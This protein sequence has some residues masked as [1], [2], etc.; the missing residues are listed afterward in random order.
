MTDDWIASYPQYLQLLAVGFLWINLH[1]A[2]MC[3]PLVIGL[4]LGGVGEPGDA[5]GEGSVADLS[6]W[7][8]L[9]LA[10]GNLAAYQ[11]G[12]SVTYAAM[13]AAAGW[14]G[15]VL[16]RL[17]SDVTRI[18][19]LVVAVGLVGAGLMSLL[20][21]AAR[22][23][24]LSSSKPGKLMGELVNRMRATGGRRRRFGLGI[25]LG[26]LPCMIPVWVLGLAAS[27][28]SPFHGAALMVMLVWMT[29]FV[30]FGFGMA[31]AIATARTLR[32]QRRLLP[33][34]LMLSGMWLGFIAMAANGWIDHRSV[35]FTLGGR[36][37]AIMFW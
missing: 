27:T 3:G 30:I 15:A 25:V 24:A 28:Q 13:G 9:R 4:N 7:Q 14:A 32:W 1:C 26:F 33:V 16:Q 36:G 8:R 10:S 17:L 29:S 21:P 23:P 22:I 35:G 5:Q 31:P 37:Y 6:R 19:G 20:R 2:G 18:A 12:R 34:A 11:L